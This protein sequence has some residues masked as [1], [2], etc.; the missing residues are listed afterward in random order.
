MSPQRLVRVGGRIVGDHLNALGARGGRTQ[1][2]PAEGQ[3]GRAQVDV[4][5]DESRRHKGAVEILHLG[6]RELTAAN[7]VATQPGHDVAAH[8]HGCGVGVG[9]AVH[10]AVDQQLGGR[11]R[12]TAKLR[13]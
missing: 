6:V 4:A 2:Q 8:R 9:R 12:H 1:I 3:T 11:L 7:V 10:P 5:V 13:G